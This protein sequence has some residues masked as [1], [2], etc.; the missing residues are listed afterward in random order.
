MSA[1]TDWP[2]LMR[3]AALR[4]GVPPHRF[5]RLSLAEWRAITQRDAASALSRAGFEALSA[6]HPDEPA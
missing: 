5:W 3:L 1:P 2:G 6:L 4:F